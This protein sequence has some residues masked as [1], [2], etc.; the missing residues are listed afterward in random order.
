MRVAPLLSSSSLLLIYDCLFSGVLVVAQTPS[1]APT[2]PS[3]IEQP[4]SRPSKNDQ[5]TPGATFTIQWTPDPAFS[6][7]TLELW[8]KTSWGYSRDFGD[9]CYH[10]INPFCGTIATHAPNTGSFEWS[11]PNPG[12]DFP[13]D[14]R[15]FWIKMYVDDYWKPDVGNTDP[16]LSYSQNFAFALAPGQ[17]PT[18]LSSA[19]PE[20]TSSMAMDVGPGTV[21][22]TV[23]DDPTSSTAVAPTTSAPASASASTSALPE[24]SSIPAVPSQGMA[25]R[26]RAAF[27]AGVLLLL[28]LL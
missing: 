6:N 4:I 11:I 27:P 14:E 1:P 21:T 24:Q 9:L 17:T 12:S 26:L 19:V 13:R 10:W 22:I 25:S 7:V 28:G 18:K 20:E 2:Q 8:D 16:V 15:V 23:W 5:L 3:V